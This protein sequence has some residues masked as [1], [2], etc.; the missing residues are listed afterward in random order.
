MNHIHTVFQS[1]SN[2]IVLRQVGSD[3]AETLAD[4]V[5]FIGLFRKKSVKVPHMADSPY[6]L[7][8]SVHLVFDTVD[9]NG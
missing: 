9:R 1:N 4:L 5:C 8:V 2:D 7:P 6:L 3:G